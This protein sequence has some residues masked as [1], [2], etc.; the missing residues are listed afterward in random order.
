MTDSINANV[1]V[2]MPSQLFTMARSFK[3]V[4]NGKIYIGKIDTD[5]VNPENRIQV[6]VENED[7]SHVPVSQPIIIN[8]AG[9]PV[10][11]GQIA[12]FVTVQ[13]HSMA[14]YDA[15]GSQQ[16]YFPNVLKYDPDQFRQLVEG[17]NGAYYIG[18]N[19]TNVGVY[20]NSYG[21]VVTPGDNLKAI[22]ESANEN[23]TVHI[24]GDVEL[25]Q[26]VI[27]TKSVSID[28][29]KGRVIWSGTGN[30]IRYIPPVLQT[31][32]DPVV[33]T[34][35]Q[36]HAQFPEGHTIEVGHMLCC[37]SNERRTGSSLGDYFRGQYFF[38]RKVSG[39]H[40]EFYPSI[41]EGFTSN[42]IEIRKP[43][44]NMQHYFRLK[45][46]TPVGTPGGVIFDMPYS[47]NCSGYVELD[48]NRDPNVGFGI[49]GH[50]HSF[51]FNIQGITNG[52]TGYNVSG[53]GIGAT[54]TR[55]HFEGT[56]SNCRHLTEIPDGSILSADIHFDINATKEVGNP[57][58]LYIAGAH[59]NVLGWSLSGR[60]SGSGGMV[61]D[62]SGTCHFH[63]LHFDCQ[64]DGYGD[65]YYCIGISELYPTQTLIENVTMTVSGLQR[66]TFVEWDIKGQSTQNGL[67]RIRDC[68]TKGR[69]RIIKLRDTGA[70]ATTHTYRLRIESCSGEAASI[71]NRDLANS[72]VYLELYNNTWSTY[73]LDSFPDYMAGSDSTGCKTYEVH[74]A[75]NVFDDT[76]TLGIFSFDGYMDEIRFSSQADKN[77]ARPFIKLTPSYLGRIGRM[78]INGLNTMG[79]MTLT[80]LEATVYND[81]GQVR[82]CRIGY[83]SPTPV[84]IGLPWPVVFTGNSFNTTLDVTLVS[85]KRPQA[86]NVNLSGKSLNWNGTNIAI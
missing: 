82:F 10:Y 65:G 37:Y 76:N 63:N 21:V 7:G 36:S 22:L 26:S 16:F 8:A 60:I 39:T 77:T 68:I 50:N 25:S 86:G 56:G 81:I 31:Y 79:Q 55:M 72:N 15:Y 59:C 67:L 70:G 2:S 44:A 11:N 9:Y 78:D 4:A 29:T 1:V 18:Y 34:G 74:S 57:L 51:R 43:T 45:Q 52:A 58:Y 47:L 24:V 12:K 3:A 54:G 20:L 14:V 53:Y 64:D 27:L 32:T 35:G 33:F 49:G 30:C 28:C 69:A 83:N 73:G 19:N 40:V 41:L 75:N 84:S 6:Y 38:V 17:S 48:C 66:K 80:P 85:T 23:E 13:G 42:K 61:Q 62:R 5:P 46:I 71:H